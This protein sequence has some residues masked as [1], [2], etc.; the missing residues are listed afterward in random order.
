MVRPGNQV[1]FA[2]LWANFERRATA[3]AHLKA[4]DYAHM[5]H[6]RIRLPAAKATKEARG[7]EHNVDPGIMVALMLHQLNT[8]QR[9][10]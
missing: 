10:A 2:W 5:R 1:G 4:D 7:V 9:A 6:M 8:M 3:L